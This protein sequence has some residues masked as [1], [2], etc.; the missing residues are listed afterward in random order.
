[1]K[2]LSGL[3]RLRDW[4]PIVFVR[5]M[6]NRCARH[7][8]SIHA[9]ALA[10]YTLLSTVPLLFF[11]LSVASLFVDAAEVQ[12]LSLNTLESLLPASTQTVRVNI[13]SIL[14]YRGTLGT[15][16]ALGALWSASGMFTVLE[17]AINAVW[18]RCQPRTFWKRRLIGILS[19]LSV[20]AW[21]LFAFI[22]R[23]LWQLLPV[24]FPILEEL[25]PPFP[26]WTERG[27]SLLSVVILNLTVF[28]FFPTKPVSWRRAIC[29][30][31]GVSVVW[32]VSRELFAWALTAGL[33][34][35]PLLYGSLWS[36]VVPIVWAYWSYLI[37]L[38]GAELQAYLEERRVGIQPRLASPVDC[39]R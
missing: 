12:A 15:V 25:A 3:I 37:L 9:A 11:I 13:E 14:R 29:I 7:Q 21:V 4:G 36:I 34:R 17:N 2:V 26:T 38:L 35:Y 28:R 20:T 31:L 16:A 1:M 32:V 18:E 23:T 5:E 24:W 27:L 10:Y 19:L 33:I 39:A 22:A 8:V 30:G 6:A